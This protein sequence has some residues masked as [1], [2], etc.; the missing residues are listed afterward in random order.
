MGDF[1]S[2]SGEIRLT[3]YKVGC[4]EVNTYIRS[5]P[6]ATMTPL[7]ESTPSSSI[8]MWPVVKNTK[9]LADMVFFNCTKVNS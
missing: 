9:P 4:R 8:T 5:S 6:S 2:N 3:K 7:S 1:L